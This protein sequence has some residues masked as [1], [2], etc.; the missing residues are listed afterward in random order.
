[1]KVKEK[2]AISSGKYPFGPKHHFIKKKVFSWRL[3]KFFRC[4]E[5]KYHAVSGNVFSMSVLYLNFC[6]C[7][8]SLFCQLIELGSEFGLQRAQFWIWLPEQQSPWNLRAWFK[9]PMCNICDLPLTHR[10]RILQKISLDCHLSRI[11]HH[12]S[13]NFPLGQFYFIGIYRKLFYWQD[14]LLGLVKNLL[15]L[16]FYCEKHTFR[17]S[18]FS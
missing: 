1:M 13:H 12:T 2:L 4:Y 9:L 18:C 8:F 5:W 16:T 17:N 3:G 7:K 14:N 6:H 11:E 10:D 15:H